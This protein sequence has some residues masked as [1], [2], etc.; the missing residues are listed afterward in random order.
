M[1][2][3][4]SSAEGTAA[5]TLP[6]GSPKHRQTNATPNDATSASER[7]F[8][9][10]CASS[11]TRPH[12][13]NPKDSKARSQFI[14]SVLDHT[15]ARARRAARLASSSSRFLLPLLLFLPLPSS[16]NS[17]ASKSSAIPK[18]FTCFD[19]RLRKYS[20]SAASFCSSSGRIFVQNSGSSMST[21]LS[22]ATK[23]ARENTE[24]EASLC[25]YEMRV[26][27]D[28]RISSMSAS[29]NFWKAASSPSLMKMSC[30]PRLSIASISVRSCGGPCLPSLSPS[31]A[32]S[33]FIARSRPSFLFARSTIS[34]SYV[35]RV[36]SR[37][38]FTLRLCPM[39]CDLAMACTSF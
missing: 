20:A 35:L 9:P 4:S 32:L 5:P 39:R 27:D 36:T 10:P 17:S 37:K 13:P 31:F 12:L 30:A 25:S 8:V 23:A 2:R 29:L 7:I 22:S 21:A 6:M 3:C 28:S 18:R 34:D 33:A 24:P 26:D 38:T 11:F 16:R 1:P 14:L 19:L 15:W